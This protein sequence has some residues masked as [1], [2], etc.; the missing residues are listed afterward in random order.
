MPSTDQELDTA[1]DLVTDALTFETAGGRRVTVEE[2]ELAERL[3]L[4][5]ETVRL[6]LEAFAGE[7]EIPVRLCG[8]TW[9]VA[10]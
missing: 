8:E 10:G 9:E 6:V 2:T 7:P 5:E 4:R 3:G 1:V